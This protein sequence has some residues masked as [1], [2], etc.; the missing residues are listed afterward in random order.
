MPLAHRVGVNVS[1]VT[2]LPGDSA[3]NWGGMF[4]EAIFTAG[5]GTP[6]WTKVLMPRSSMVHCTVY[7]AGARG[8]IFAFRVTVSPGETS[9]GIAVQRIFEA[10]VICLPAASN[11]L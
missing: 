5:P 11:R 8:A 2:P 1:T 3:V 10:S 6:A 7:V 9:C 4:T